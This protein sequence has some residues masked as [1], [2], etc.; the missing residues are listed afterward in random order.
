MTLPVAPSGP[1][2]EKVL[3]Q[4]LHAMAGGD[5]PVLRPGPG[6]SGAAGST[7]ATRRLSILQIL[8]I[9][10]LLGLCVGIPVGLVSLV[11]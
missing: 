1:D 10:V 6:L 2:P 9:A 7:P 5:K 11:G 4:A 8:L 3:A